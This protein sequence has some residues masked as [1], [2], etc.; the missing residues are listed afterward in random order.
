MKNIIIGILSS[1]VFTIA[2]NPDEPTSSVKLDC[3]RIVPVYESIITDYEPTFEWCADESVDSFRFQL[4]KKEDFSTL[5]FDNFT[6]I[7]S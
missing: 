4:S 2:C 3:G 6:Q 7:N 5:L 1:L